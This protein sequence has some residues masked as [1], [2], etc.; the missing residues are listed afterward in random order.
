VRHA[1]PV[2]LLTAQR[3]PVE[4]VVHRKEYVQ[5]SR[6]GRVA[7]KNQ[8]V[9]AEEHA[10]TG[11]LPT[12]IDLSV[13]VDGGASVGVQGD[14]IFSTLTM[15]SLR[16]ASV[17]LSRSWSNSFSL[18]RNSLR[19]TSHSSCVTIFGRFTFLSFRLFAAPTAAVQPVL[20]AFQAAF[21]MPTR[22]I[23]VLMKVTPHTQRGLR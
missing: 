6:V 23:Q 2:F 17:N 12:K 13:V 22:T 3:S 19:A 18:T 14:V 10:Q 9:V 15:G 8:I 7:V 21:T 5:P 1:G 16:R 20:E 4:E 11:H